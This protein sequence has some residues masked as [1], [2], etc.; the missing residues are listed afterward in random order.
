MEKCLEGKKTPLAV[1]ISFQDAGFSEGSIKNTDRSSLPVKMSVLQQQTS[2]V[3][4][5]LLEMR[6]K[7][8]SPAH[9]P[10]VYHRFFSIKIHAFLI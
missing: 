5:C 10:L 7:I 1:K 2:S 8:Q 9:G 3:G 6:S 4:L